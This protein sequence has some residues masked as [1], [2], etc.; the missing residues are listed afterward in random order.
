MDFHKRPFFSSLMC[1][2][3]T[4]AICYYHML[5][6]YVIM[7][8]L[9]HDT[10]FPSLTLLCRC[11][12]LFLSVLVYFYL[13]QISLPLEYWCTLHFRISWSF[14]F[15]K[16]WTTSTEPYLLFSRQSCMGEKGGSRREMSTEAQN[17]IRRNPKLNVF[18][19]NKH[20]VVL[21]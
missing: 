13:M 10:L 2:Q 21:Q 16:N 15:I 19:R 11:E 5:L 6:S 4:W 20:V 3:P 12:V 14:P 7:I 9:Y 17:F 1:L 8:C 18:Q